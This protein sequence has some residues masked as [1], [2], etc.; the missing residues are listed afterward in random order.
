[1][2]W[3]RGWAELSQ[4]VQLFSSHDLILSNQSSFYS[5]Y[6][7]LCV[8]VNSDYLVNLFLS[9]LCRYIFAWEGLYQIL[10]YLYF[11]LYLLE[12][13]L[14]LDRAGNHLMLMMTKKPVKPSLGRTMSYQ[15]GV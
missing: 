10:Q 8:K 3:L 9:L 14:P 15:A 7:Y 1:M 12:D 13:L 11:L 4:Q 6:V 2:S 5:V